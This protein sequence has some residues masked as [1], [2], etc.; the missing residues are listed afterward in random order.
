[1]ILDNLITEHML[2]KSTD[3]LNYSSVGTVENY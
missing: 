3:L 1:M 2:L